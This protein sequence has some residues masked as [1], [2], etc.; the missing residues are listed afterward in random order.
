MIIL[1]HF[2]FVLSCCDFDV[3][4]ECLRGCSDL[5]CGCLIITFIGPFH[6]FSGC[7]VQLVSTF[8]MSLLTVVSSL[9]LCHYAN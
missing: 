2:T 7:L 9:S 5:H 4:F 6:Y 3:Q 8:V 1:S